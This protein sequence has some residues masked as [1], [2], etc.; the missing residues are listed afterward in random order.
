MAVGGLVV[1]GGCTAVVLNLGDGARVAAVASSPAAATLPDLRGKSLEHARV[2]AEAGGWDLESDSL[3]GGDTC[4]DSDACFVYRVKPGVGE[5]VQ[6][7]GKVEVR[8]VTKSERAWYRKH[9]R[10]PKVVGWTEE[11][12][13]KSF[14]P[15]AG[16]VT[17]ESEE[18]AGVP[19]GQV[20]G[21]SPKAGKP[22]KVGQAV[23]LTVSRGPSDTGAGDPDVDV[24]NHDGESKFCS[25]RKWC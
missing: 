9:T 18:S 8:Y 11:R 7:G 5:L 20:I 13:R 17:S 16:A 22:L 4:P 24:D 21:Q 14:A 6:P 23:K 3:A 10:M 15:V 1:L 12:A 25:R 2:K 19:T